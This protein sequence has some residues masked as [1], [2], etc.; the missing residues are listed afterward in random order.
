MS[1]ST[2]LM[3]LQD[4]EETKVILVTLAET[5]PVL[6]A[7]G[8]QTDLEH[9]EIHP[10][11]WVVNNSLVATAPASPLLR[12]RASEELRQID[13]VRNEHCT[14]LAVVPM[15]P[16]EPVGIPALEALGGTHVPLTL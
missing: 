2:P 14:R 15:F 7:A 16:T 1:F 10:W 9:A 13:K 6:E 4:P 8:L 12:R 5:T 3:R 11:A